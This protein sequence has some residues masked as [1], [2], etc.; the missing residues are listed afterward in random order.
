MLNG[1]NGGT[2]VQARATRRVLDVKGNRVKVHEGAT[3]IVWSSVLFGREDE[4]EGLSQQVYFETG[5]NTT[6]CVNFPYS[7][8]AR[9]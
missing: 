7:H 3:G 2:V 6:Y 5:Q 9:L 4:E 1:F 8:M